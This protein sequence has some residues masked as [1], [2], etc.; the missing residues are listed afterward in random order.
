MS[1]RETSENWRTETQPVPAGGTPSARPRVERPPLD[2]R[3]TESLRSPESD[4]YAEARP[5]R[6]PDVIPET[7]PGLGRR[8]QA[9]MRADLT[10][11]RQRAPIRRV[12]RTVRHID[13]FSMLKLSLFF[14][15]CFLV[16]WLVF[17]AIVY[18]VV[19]SMGVFETIEEIGRNF[20]LWENVNISLW[21]VEK[22][23][24]LIGL[25]LAVIGAL[26]NAFLAFLYNVGADFVGGLE[27]TFSERDFSG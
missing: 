22:W 26:V 11:P 12:R 4:P 24:F 7:T 16:L 17:V 1:S 21:L 9:G 19:E 15:A 3:P 27:L 5:T 10:S 2:A 23:A 8:S 13:P 6:A 14:Y 25:T 20:V 18:F